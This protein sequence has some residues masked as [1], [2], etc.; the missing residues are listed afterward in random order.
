MATKTKA[1]VTTVDPLATMPSNIKA[2][3]QRIIDAVGSERTNWADGAIEI[4]VKDANGVPIGENAK[5]KKERSAQYTALTLASSVVFRYV[6]EG[7]TL[8]D[9]PHN[10]L[11]AGT[12]AHKK[13][14]KEAQTHFASCMNRALVR[15]GY[16][17]PTI[18]ASA[19]VTTSTTTAPATGVAPSA[20]NPLDGRMISVA[21]MLTEIVER[22]GK[23]D[24]ALVAFQASHQ[25]TKAARA[26]IGDIAESFGTLRAVISKL[27]EL[28]VPE[29]VKDAAAGV[30]ANLPPPVPGNKPQPEPTPEPATA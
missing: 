17:E 21:S 13:A 14:T 30:A 19:A 5:L 15:L 28:I 18:R 1:V 12:D 20:P 24:S 16:R 11:V 10:T 2:L 27:A 3:Y 6:S 25:L 8:F 29:T 7:K 26:G 23:M 4:G 22:A 9:G